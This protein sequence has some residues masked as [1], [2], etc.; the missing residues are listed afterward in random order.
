MAKFLSSFAALTISAIILL[1]SSEATTVG[2]V[3]QIASVQSDQEFCFFLPPEK[4]GDIAK[5]EDRAIAFCTKPLSAAPGARLFPPGFIQTANFAQNTEK[6]WVQVTGKMSPSVYDLPES[7]SGGQY[8]IKAPVGSAC[9][10]Y[11][12]FV[13]LVEP[14]E[15]LACF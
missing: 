15:Y 13:N 4:G 14:G 1:S 7:D 2:K 11:N 8:D 9:A 12:Y 10:N 5:N 3:G 6:D